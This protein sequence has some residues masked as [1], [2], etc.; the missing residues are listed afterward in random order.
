MP[1]TD[2]GL[3]DRRYQLGKVLGRGPSGVVY[4]ATDRET[5]KPCAVK[6]LHAQFYDRAV[7][8]QVQR[9]AEAAA[10]INHPAILA[11][12]RTGFEPGGALYLVMPLLQGESLAQRLLRGPLSLTA[13]LALL[14]PLCAA[15][16]AAH[17]IGLHHGAITPTN[18]MC[19]SNGG[20]MV[21]DFGVCHLRATPKVQWGGS[22]GYAAP[23]TFEADSELMSSRG[24][25]FSLGALVFECLTGTRMFSATTVATFVSSVKTPPPLGTLLPKYANLDAVLEMASTL[26]PDDRFANAGALWRAL[27]SSLL[28]MPEQVEPE[29]AAASRP[30]PAAGIKAPRISEPRASEPRPSEPRQGRPVRAMAVIALPAEAAGAN[31]GSSGAFAR[32]PEALPPPPAGPESGIPTMELP[33]IGASSPALQP[34]PPSRSSNPPPPPPPVAHRS[35]PLLPPGAGV[36]AGHV[37]PLRPPSNR[38]DPELI[39]PTDPGFNLRAPR[40]VVPE[41]AHPAVWAIAGGALVA[42]TILG[43]Q[44]IANRQPTTSSPGATTPTYVSVPL[45][46]AAMLQRAQNEL[47]QRSYA[48]ALSYAELLLRIQ[49]Q[50][51]QARAIADQASET[52]RS[53]AIYGGFLRAADRGAASIAAAL[54]RE[55]PT[56]SSFRTQAWEP[57]PQ[58]RSQFTRSRLNLAEAASN[59]GLCDEIRTQ[60]D[61]LRWVADSDADPA[62]QQSQ[63]LLGKCKNGAPDSAA[64]S[65]VPATPS[66]KQITDEPDTESRPRRR[67]RS[68]NKSEGELKGFPSGKKTPADK[69]EAE[70][71]EDKPE[72]PRGLRNPFGP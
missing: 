12:Q 60:I 51:V 37:V 52:L 5:G 11:V 54:Y 1:T 21:S 40:P 41:R 31:A 71:K 25:V 69:P 18:V 23:E 67:R 56:G 9:D 48:T 58:V 68:E 8:A 38:F 57:F 46:E 45:D 35:R 14:E 65:A 24:D 63:R 20:V 29:V 19:A 2:N 43:A 27:Q 39:I 62:L 44:W 17:D 28:E 6:R 33:V 32:G 7:L 59:S 16:Q 47:A 72:T 53:S 70:P 42:L 3:L 64:A 66:R 26:L 30:I 55:L 15:L 61:R 49:P 13:T 36:P 4:A 10:K 22:M 34:L 50:H